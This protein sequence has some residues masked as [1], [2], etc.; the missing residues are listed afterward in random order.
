MTRPIE[1]EARA[2]VEAARDW[3][4]RALPES[5]SAECTWCPVC[6][7]VAALRSPEAAEKITTAVTAA[8]GTL[9]SFLDALTRPTPPAPDPAPAGSGSGGAAEPVEI[10]VDGAP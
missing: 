3:A 9:A 5:H 2:L 7:T 4:V 1:D 10:P 6:R 8:A